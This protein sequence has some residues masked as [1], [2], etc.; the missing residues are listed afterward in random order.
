MST[1]TQ[2]ETW[3]RQRILSSKFSAVTRGLVFAHTQT[4]WN[5]CSRRLESIIARQ[6]SMIHY[7][8]QAVCGW[9]NKLRASVS[10]REREREREA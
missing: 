6:H 3:K 2:F 1:V 5:I 9:T 4:V 7:S 8:K 10:E